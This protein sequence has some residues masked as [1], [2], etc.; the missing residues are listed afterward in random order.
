MICLIFVMEMGL[1]L[2]KGLFNRIKVGLVVSV[3]VILIW[4]FFLLDN[5]MFR[6]LAIW[7][8]WNFFNS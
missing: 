8:M 7:L 1:I 6:E 4:R 5:D 2:A 3:W